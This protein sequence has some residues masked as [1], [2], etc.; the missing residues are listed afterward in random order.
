MEK[1]TQQRRP[2]SVLSGRQNIAGLPSDAK[3][4]VQRAAQDPDS[5][6][7]CESALDGPQCIGGTP[8]R[9]AKTTR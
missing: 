9:R 6:K 7:D 8:K 5:N 4:A 3:S 2:S 1:R